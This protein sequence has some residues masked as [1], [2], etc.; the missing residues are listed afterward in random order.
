MNPISSIGATGLSAAFDRFNASAQ[1]TASGESD[2][3]AEAVVQISAR[4]A[5]AANVA[6]IKTQDEMFRRLLDIKV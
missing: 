4:Q 1:R 3:A 6:V 5:V 2:L